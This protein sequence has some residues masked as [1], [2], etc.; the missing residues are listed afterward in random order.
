MAATSLT[1]RRANHITSLMI[2]KADNGFSLAED[3][4]PEHITSK[5]SLAL[6]ARIQAADREI[7]EIDDPQSDRIRSLRADR[8]ECYR[9][10][11]DGNKRLVCKIV[12]G[13]W[14]S[15]SSISAQQMFDAG[16]RGV[17]MAVPRFDLS[18]GTS[19]STYATHWIRSQ[20]QEDEEEAFGPIWVPVNLRHL[21]TKVQRAATNLGYTG[22]DLSDCPSDILG[23]AIESVYATVNDRRDA[24]RSKRFFYEHMM[25]SIQL[26]YHRA[27]CG[28]DGDFFDPTDEIKCDVS[29]DDIGD[30]NV[31]SLM[32]DAIARL[33]SLG[34][35]WVRTADILAMRFG[36]TT[37]VRMSL[38]EIG[39][40][41]NI[42]R[43]RVRQ[44]EERGI[45][46][47]TQIVREGKICA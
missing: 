43:E 2:R 34:G 24:K 37:G 22:M 25:D 32:R 45:E 41:F 13:L 18:A 29:S 15:N 4:L 14:R 23:A 5:E 38:R 19:F 44:L 3:D 30:E 8:D 28:E 16:L 42:N 1:R 33:R 39:K 17:Y 40:V 35:S 46:K 27:G 21:R 31:Y 47:I 10:L 12:A 6:V 7:G 20:I 26:R 9:K 11:I 36:F